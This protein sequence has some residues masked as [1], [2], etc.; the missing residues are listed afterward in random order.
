MAASREL[1]EAASA[2]L[3]ARYEQR[4]LQP[5]ARGRGARGELSRRLPPA[6]RPRLA[7]RPASK[8][9]PLPLTD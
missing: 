4:L 9:L 2:V 5:G 7:R 1:G 8:Q 6:P 3:S